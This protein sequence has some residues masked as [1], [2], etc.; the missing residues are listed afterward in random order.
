MNIFVNYE[1][2]S[3][4]DFLKIALWFLLNPEIKVDWKNLDNMDIPIYNYCNEPVDGLKITVTHEPYG[5]YLLC[6]LMEDGSVKPSTVLAGH[7]IIDFGTS[8][9]KQ[10]RDIRVHE[11]AMLYADVNNITKKEALVRLSRAQVKNQP[12]KVK[13]AIKKRNFE[14]TVLGGHWSFSVGSRLEDI[15]EFYKSVVGKTFN[16][17]ITILPSKPSEQIMIRHLDY[18]KNNGVENRQVIN[19]SYNNLKNMIEL[20]RNYT[21]AKEMS[22]RYGYNIITFSEL[23]CSSALDLAKK[24]ATYIEGIKVNE[25]YLEF[26]RRYSEL[27]NI[28]SLLKSNKLKICDDVIDS[29]M[30]EVDEWV[31]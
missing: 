4:G 8:Y 23:H 26:H 9:Q 28:P 20:M 1:A 22:K 2:G 10:V 16:R 7:D 27:N 30:K 21:T 13:E 3:G 14:H 15:N 17:V 12:R 24:L 29:F 6:S 18:I 11:I 5:E 19:D 31:L 25:T